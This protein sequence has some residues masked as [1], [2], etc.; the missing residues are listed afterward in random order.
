[1]HHRVG[2]SQSSWVGLTAVIGFGAA[3]GNGS[4]NRPIFGLQSLFG[5]AKAVACDIKG[6]VSLT[7]GER[8]YHVPG[9]KR[10]GET[11]IDPKFGERWFCSEAEAREAGWRKARS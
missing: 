9:Q 11:R 7:S 4:I 8:I 1:M 5:S 3:V 10:Y 6:N 2:H